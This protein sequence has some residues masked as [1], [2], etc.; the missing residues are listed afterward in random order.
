MPKDSLSH[1]KLI[2]SNGKKVKAGANRSNISSNIVVFWCLM[3]CLNGLCMYKIFTFFKKEEKFVFDGVWW[4]MFQNIFSSNIFW[5]KKWKFDVWTCLNCLV[6]FF[7]KHF[8]FLY[9]WL[10]YYLHS[11]LDAGDLINNGTS[12]STIALQHPFIM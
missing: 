6:D 11:C 5:V 8:E 2:D 4:N 3:K 10:P 12:F 7:I 9:A 1:S